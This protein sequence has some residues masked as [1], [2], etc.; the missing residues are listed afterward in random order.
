[1][2][3]IPM[4]EIVYK[5]CNKCDASFPTSSFNK[6]LTK[7][8]GLN[9]YCKNCRRKMSRDWKDRTNYTALR[10]YQGS[11]RDFSIHDSK[12]VRLAKKMRAHK[13]KNIKELRLPTKKLIKKLEKKI[14][15]AQDKK[16]VAWLIKNKTSLK[17]IFATLLIA[18]R[19]LQLEDFKNYNKTKRIRKHPSYYAP[20]HAKRRGLKVSAVLPSADY[21]LIKEFF[22]ESK[23]KTES[24]GLSYHV[25][26]I[27]P[28]FVGGSHHQ[29]NLQVI[30][31]SDN[32][33]KQAS[34]RKED[35]TKVTRWALNKQ[36]VENKFSPHYGK[37]C[38]YSIP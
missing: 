35:I 2:R 19:K 7:G 13:I 8:D 24:T 3:G 38:I 10:K 22:R 5:H 29:D 4:S 34:F 15:E 26:H 27:I 21:D 31:A 11:T 37:K 12:A 33:S 17:I 16:H 1:V 23:L 18:A 25:D 32:M 36:S 14:K 28:L 9:I 30:L 20:H 6:D